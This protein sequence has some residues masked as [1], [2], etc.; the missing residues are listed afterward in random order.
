MRSPPD[1]TIS[2][3]VPLYKRI[4]FVEHQLAQFGHD[5]EIGQADLI[6]VLDSPEAADD[7]ARLAPAL[8]RLHGVPFRSRR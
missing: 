1:P 3:I 8:Q 6:Y 5:P 2:I 4:D 7:L